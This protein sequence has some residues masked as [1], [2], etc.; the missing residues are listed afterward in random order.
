MESIARSTKRE[1]DMIMQAATQQISG[2][3]SYLTPTYM[4]HMPYEPPRKRQIRSP[5]IDQQEATRGSVLRDGSK[6]GTSR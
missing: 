6:T 1:T 2:Y 4:S 5:F 3:P